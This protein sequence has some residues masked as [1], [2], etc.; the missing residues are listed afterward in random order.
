MGGG[1][2]PAVTSRPNAYVQ[3]SGLRPVYETCCGTLTN[4]PGVSTLENPVYARRDLSNRIVRMVQQAHSTIPNQKVDVG[5]TLAAEE[6][7]KRTKAAREVV[8]NSRREILIY[9]IY[10]LPPEK[11][12]IDATRRPPSAQL[13]RQSAAGEPGEEP[14]AEEKKMS[15][16]SCLRMMSMLGACAGEGK[17][18]PCIGA[19]GCGEDTADPQGRPITLVEATAPGRVSPRFVCPAAPKSPRDKGVSPAAAY[20]RWHPAGGQPPRGTR[21]GS[22]PS[23]SPRVAEPA[24]FPPSSSSP[25][26]VHKS[27]AKRPTSSCVGCAPGATIES[28]TIAAAPRPA[29]AAVGHTPRRAPSPAPNATATATATYASVATGSASL[30]PRGETISM[31]NVCSVEAAVPSTLPSAEAAGRGG[32]GCGSAGQSQRASRPTS[33]RTDRAFTISEGDIEMTDPSDHAG[34]PAV[35]P[36][37]A[38]AA[39]AATPAAD[40]AGKRRAHAALPPAADAAAPADEEAGG[41]P[42]FSQYALGEAEA[43]AQ[44]KPTSSSGRRAHSQGAGESRTARADKARQILREAV[45]RSNV[46]QGVSQCASVNDAITL[47]LSWGGASALASVMNAA[48]H[49]KRIVEAL[50]TTEFFADLGGMQLSMMAAAGKT[51]KL[52]RYAVLFREGSDSTCFYVLTKGCLQESVMGGQGEERPPIRATGRAAAKF[53]LLGIEALMRKPRES[54][55]I[56]LENSEAPP[57]RPS[58]RSSEP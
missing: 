35:A 42:I 45:R 57:L 2:R 13:K 49:T 7:K 47:G 53:V 8:E 14:P 38:P 29:L 37:V 19:C 4:A 21:P 17:E 1:L 43:A 56:A 41:S 15:T 12:R 36:P 46:S 24:E 9:E 34:A 31:S 23:L 18:T 10:Q 55:F 20:A 11:Q 54:G 28:Q 58:P 52:A 3:A 5:V 39:C 51:F 30:L 26:I 27:P 6:E 32:G 50:Q 25:S 16:K 40:V 48:V 33:A 44:L 22:G